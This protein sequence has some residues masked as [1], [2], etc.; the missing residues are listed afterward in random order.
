MVVR[1]GT[2]ITGVGTAFTSPQISGRSTLY[3]LYRMY[4]MRYEDQAFSIM[5]NDELDKMR[6]LLKKEE[7]LNDR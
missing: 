6:Q 3:K 1:K 5:P 2:G 4:D 7:R